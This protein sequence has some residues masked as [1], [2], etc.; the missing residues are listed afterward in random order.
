MRCYLQEG[1]YPTG[2]PVP[3]H[4]LDYIS[5]ALLRSMTIVSA[6][7]NIGSYVPPSFDMGWGR[8]DADSVLHFPGQDR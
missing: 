3:T 6:D 4:E 5:A 8:L 1:Y 7:P 2:K